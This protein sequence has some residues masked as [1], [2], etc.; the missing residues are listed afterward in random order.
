MKKTLYKGAYKA[1]S[2]LSDLTG[3]A[4]VVAR[5]KVAIAAVVLSLSAG[6][7]SGCKPG[8]VMCYATEEPPTEQ[9]E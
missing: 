6:A 9:T 5:W 3:G 2:A 7:M 1:V 8:E 4:P